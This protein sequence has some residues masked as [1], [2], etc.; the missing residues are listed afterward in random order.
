MNQ[1]TFRRSCFFI[2]ALSALIVLGAGQV[3]AQSWNLPI[4]YN[5]PG[6]INTTLT[7]ADSKRVLGYADYP[8]TTGFT[9]EGIKITLA[10]GTVTRINFPG[11]TATFLRGCDPSG[12]VSGSYRDSSNLLHGFTQINGTF[13]THDVPGAVSTEL[14]GLST[15]QKAAVTYYANSIYTGA[16]YDLSKN[17][18]SAI[19]FPPG[20]M[21]SVAYDITDRDQ[22]VV[23]Y[24][25]IGAIVHGYI[26]CPP[27]GILNTIDHPNATGNFT[28]IC[29]I[30][31]HGFAVG[32][33]YDASLFTH[34]YVRTP[35]GKFID[36]PDPAGAYTFDLKGINGKNTLVGTAT[37]ALGNSYGLLIYPRVTVAQYLLNFDF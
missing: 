10:D 3:Y 7:F 14:F 33:Y 27:T 35:F 25:S 8:S 17:T 34:A 22:F 37:N 28:E 29:G 23:G 15:T 19:P 11:A 20:T 32:T 6:S 21:A 18:I 31:G 16:I 2:L 12:N 9:T 26:Y 30:N 13:V 5:A 36:I 1:M 24:Y 4:T